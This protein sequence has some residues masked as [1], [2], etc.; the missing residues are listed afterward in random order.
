MMRWNCFN[1][2]LYWP[3]MRNYLGIFFQELRKVNKTSV[4]IGS[5][6]SKI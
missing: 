2:K 4:R 6:W 5:L 1:R 3:N